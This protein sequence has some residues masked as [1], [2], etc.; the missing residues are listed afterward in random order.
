[1]SFNEGGG[2]RGGAK[3]GNADI[4]FREVLLKC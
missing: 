4:L 2:G 3:F 1:M